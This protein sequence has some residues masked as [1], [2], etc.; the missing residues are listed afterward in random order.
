MVILF[1][2]LPC[3][4]LRSPQDTVIRI[5]IEGNPLIQ[6]HAACCRS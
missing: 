5:D 4:Y 2:Y 6:V 1:L 3:F